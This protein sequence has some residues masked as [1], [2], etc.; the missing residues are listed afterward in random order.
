VHERPAKFLQP[1]DVWPLPPTET[2]NAQQEHV[3]RVFKFLG[4]MAN[5]NSPLSGR[6][7]PFRMRELMLEVDVL[8]DLILVNDALDVGKNLGSRGK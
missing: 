3:A 6:R 2:A 8:S 5:T 4:A 7:V 1:L